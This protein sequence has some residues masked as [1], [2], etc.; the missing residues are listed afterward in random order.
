MD[1]EFHEV[2]LPSDEELKKEQA[3]YSRKLA[4]NK[5]KPWISSGDDSEKKEEE[6]GEGNTSTNNLPQNQH[7]STSICLE[8]TQQ[9]SE[10]RAK[11]L[12]AICDNLLDKRITCT[13]CGRDLKRNIV[14]HRRL[15]TH[16]MLGVLMC[17]KCSSFYGEDTFSVDEDGSD[18]Y[19]RWCGDGGEL[20]C[21][22]S[23][24]LG[25]CRQCLKRNLNRS[26]LKDVESEDW[27]CFVCKPQPLWE[28]RALC[29]AVQEHTNKTGRRHNS[30]NKNDVQEKKSR[31]TT[32][33]KRSPSSVSSHSGDSDSEEQAKARKKVLKKENCQLEED[34][35]KTTTIVGRY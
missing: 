13:S 28:L 9:E 23:C 30:L 34:H 25:F 33:I 19:C 22:S 4:D 20:Y 16:P 10:Y 27:K 29:A 18:K 32:P 15:F 21:C 6:E 2:P 8:I 35:H 3:R 31:R 7:R 12:L 26:A 24:S 5:G 14:Q 1:L 11:E 17:E